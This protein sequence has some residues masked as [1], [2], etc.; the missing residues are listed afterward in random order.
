MYEH[1]NS[2]NLSQMMNYFYPSLRWKLLFAAL[3]SLLTFSS[4]PLFAQDVTY[5]DSSGNAGYTLKNSDHSRLKVNFSV[6]D[7]SF[8][9]TEIDGESL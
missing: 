9:D 3:I 1:N 7:F 8:S 2:L 6:S 4:F 5:T